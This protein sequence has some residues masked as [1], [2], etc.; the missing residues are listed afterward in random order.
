MRRKRL[1]HVANILCEMFC[2]WR[3]INSGPELV[4][5]GSGTLE[6][7]ALT[8]A[9]F[10]D[11]LP[12]AELSIAGELRDWLNQELRTNRIPIEAVVRAW[13]RADLSFSQLPWKKRSINE[14]FFNDDGQEVRTPTIHQC[15]IQC[16]SEVKTDE[17][18][19]RSDREDIEEWPA[20]WPAA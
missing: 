7:D 10:F 18:I 15:R 14:Y 4:R 5:L 1:Q 20:G 12:I 13:V 11:E 6:I 17:A 3:L 8:G 19:Y 2:G 9:C 16:E